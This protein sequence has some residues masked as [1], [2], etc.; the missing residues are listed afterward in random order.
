M[1][2]VDAARYQTLFEEVWDQVY[3]LHT[4]WTVFLCLY[5]TRTG[6]DVLRATARVTFAALGELLTEAIFLGTHRLLEKGSSEAKR[7]ASIQSLVSLLPPEAAPLRR[8]LR[9]NLSA[10]QKDCEPLTAVRHRRVVHRDLAT[11]LD[12][13]PTP[14]ERVK[15]RSVGNA[16]EVFAATLTAISD[17]LKLNLAYDLHHELDDL[18]VHE[19]IRRLGLALNL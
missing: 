2:V 10:V 9:K 15:M 17:E 8:R 4:T 19:L 1:P 3:R 13:H 16:I 18:D 5:E 12:E 11:I 7:T 14:L 6:R